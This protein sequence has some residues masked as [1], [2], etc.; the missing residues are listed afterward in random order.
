MRSGAAVPLLAAAIAASPSGAVAKTENGATAKVARGEKTVEMQI[1]RAGAQ[2]SQKG[3]E[4][5]FTGTVR[6]DPLFQPTG[7][8]DATA[9]ASAAYVTFEPCAR[10][11]WHTHPLGQVLVVTS[12]AGRVQEWGKP[13][14]EIRVGDVVWTPPGVKHWHGAAPTTAMT[15]LA[16]TEALDGK[17]VDWMEK[18][19]DQQYGAAVTPANS[20][21]SAAAGVLPSVAPA[22]AAYQDRV[23]FGELWKRPDLSPR[24]RSLVTVAALVARGQAGELARYLELALDSGVKPSELSEA[25]THLAFYSGLANATSAAA[26]AQGVFTRRGIGAG[27]LPAARVELLPLN[28]AAEAKRAAS[29][30]GNFG[31]VAPGVVKYT[32]DVLFRDLW[33]RPGLAPRDRSLVTVSALVATGQVAQITYHLN[34]AMDSGLTK[35]QASEVLT[36]LAF[37]AGWPSVFSAMP[38]VKDV[39]ASRAKP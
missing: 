23:V 28:E 17:A 19:S 11:A 38:V 5:Y 30:E 12:G 35:A 14:Q 25:I 7:S 3:P 36:Q 27:E 13:V 26:V 24:D 22:L 29:V 18:V 15:H 32:T 39:F 6:I 8:P 2:A 20:S 34:R 10:S 21:S 33:L 1:T 4:G 16:L 31:T 9:R 37:Y